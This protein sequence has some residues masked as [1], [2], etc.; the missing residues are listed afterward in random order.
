MKKSISQIP[1]TSSSREDSRRHL[2]TKEKFLFPAIISL[3]RNSIIKHGQLLCYLGIQRDNLSSRDVE[4][5]I[6]YGHLKQ[7]RI[8][9]HIHYPQK[10]LI[11]VNV[12]Q[13]MV[14]LVRNP[15]NY[16]ETGSIILGC[17]LVFWQFP[18]SVS[19]CCLSLTKLKAANRLPNS[20]TFFGFHVKW[21]FL[22]MGCVAQCQ[23]L[24]SR[25]EASLQQAPNYTALINKNFLAKYLI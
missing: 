16:C 2:L 18:T 7:L 9:H 20:S 3:W 11:H 1:H 25:G 23:S 13:W 5:C 15:R 6:E 24:I 4:I 12:A 19:L 21:I 14:P 22:G 17:L 8:C 10:G